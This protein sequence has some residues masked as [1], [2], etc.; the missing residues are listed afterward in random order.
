[1]TNTITHADMLELRRWN[2]PTI[3]NG[4]EQVTKL[5]HGREAF[6]LEETT[7]FMPQMGPMVGRAVTVVF[8]PSNPEHPRR[9]PRAWSEYRQYVAS[10]PGPKIVVVQ[11]LDKPRTYGAFWGEVNSSMHRALG[12]V[13][14]ITDGAIRDVDEITC[15]G[16]KALARRLCVGHAYSCPVRWG[17]PVEVFGRRI[18]PGQLIHADKHGFLA[19]PSTDEAG[20]LEA[21]RFLDSQEC[22][23]MIA[24]ARDSVG[25]KPEELLS[26]L[27]EAAK[28]YGVA[29]SEKYRR[30]G[31]F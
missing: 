19:I 1:M 16:F 20:L 6:N 14:T 30:Q 22:Q 29:V 10:T 12:C 5:D 15:A 23:T 18:E 13:G 9:N 8:E 27:D 11:D 3:Y 26:R 4:W 25:L 2:T 24:A 17:E 31:E 7:D 28:R 21:S